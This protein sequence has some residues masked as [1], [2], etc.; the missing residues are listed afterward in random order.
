M[1]ETRTINLQPTPKFVPPWIRG[2]DRDFHGNGPRVNL[3]T[4]LQVRNANELWAR[5]WMRAKETRSDWTEVEGSADFLMY[6]DPG[7]AEIRRILSD[8]MS[9]HTF[10][11]DNHGD[12]IRVLGTDE[13]VNS[14][15][16][17][18]DTRGDE[19]GIRTGVSVHF[20]P[21]TLEVDTMNGANKVIQVGPTPEFV[22]SHVNGDRDFNGNGPRVSVS[23][24]IDIRNTYE[25]W[26]TVW[27]D[28]VET[29]RDWT[30]ATGSTH[31]LLHRN[32]RPIIDIVSGTYSQLTYV[33]TNHRRDEF[34]LSPA[35][36]VAK[37]EC[38]GDNRG[39]EAGTRTGVT[40]H[41]NPIVIRQG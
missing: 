19:A 28:A 10:I 38:V 8:R 11:D 15:I 17:T 2:G 3:F 30:R 31:F 41:F 22:P 16:V 13:L 1:I 23:A 24:R 32:D 9:S 29:T 18:G 6:R 4:E 36:L 35:E 26:A 20:N 39:D 33:D 25:I 21:V 27:M 34:P 7:V 14:Y 40:V 12:D 37:F 5:V